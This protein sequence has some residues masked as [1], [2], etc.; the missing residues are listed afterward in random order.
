MAFIT[1][2]KIAKSITELK[3]KFTEQFLLNEIIVLPDLFVMLSCFKSGIS[4]N[5][6]ELVAV[7]NDPVK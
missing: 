5:I 2:Y 3:S 4:L 7:S 6:S 1:N